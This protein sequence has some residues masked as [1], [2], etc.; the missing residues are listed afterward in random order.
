[1]EICGRALE[2]RTV[3]QHREAGRAACLVC[4]GERRRVEVCPDQAPGRA[5][6]LDFGYQPEGI[7]SALR[8]QRLQ[9]S[10]GRLD[11]AGPRPQLGKRHCRLRRGDLLA[12]V[13]FDTRENVGHAA[14]PALETAISRSSAPIARPS[15]IAAA[16]IATP[17]G[18]EP[19]RP[20]TTRA[21][22]ALSRAMSR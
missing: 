9:K 22:P 5:R 19:A 15:S 20:A 17:S 13:G 2:R 8:L 6:L 12:L 7:G 14:L 18:S 4:A 21:A 11:I 3:G 1:A 16:A 10:A